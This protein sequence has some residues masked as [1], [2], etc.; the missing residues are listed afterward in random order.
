MKVIINGQNVEA[1][2]IPGGNLEEIL[3]EIQEHQVD[4]NVVGQ[5]LVNGKDYSEDVPHAAVELERSD[6]DTLELTT[7]TAEEI[8]AHFIENG[9][10]IVES[11]LN[12]LP[13]IVE[14]F[15][16][17]DETEANE[18]YL[19][20]LES[21][22]LLMGTLE[23]VGGILGL[24]FNSSS[25]GSASIEESMEKLSDVM[26]DLLRI[27]EENDWIYLADILEYDLA[28]ELKVF[29]AALPLISATKH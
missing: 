17:G 8:A 28:S 2:K 27:Q 19:N 20:F 21:L 3:G 6:I 16:L 1:E 9:G 23:N 4:G 12:S 14:M 18:H 25:D 29:Q 13:R 11:M 24:N 10:L 26:S 7:R 15:R 22:H 5:V